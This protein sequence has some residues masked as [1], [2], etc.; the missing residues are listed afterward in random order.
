M[1]SHAEKLIKLECKQP[2]DSQV[3]KIRIDKI[4]IRK[5]KATER[6]FNKKM[7]L[8]IAESIKVD[9]QLQPILLRNHP[10]EPG[11]YEQIA[12]LHRIYAVGTI[13]KRDEIDAYV[14]DCTEESGRM[15]TIAE[16]VFR[17]QPNKEQFFAG[18]SAW[19]KHYEENGAYK[20][21]QAGGQAKAAAGQSQDTTTPDRSPLDD[22]PPDGPT[23]TAPFDVPEK[24]KRSE[25]SDDAEI[26]QESEDQAGPVAPDEP[27]SFRA[28]V[29]AVLGKSKTSAGELI[30]IA[31]AL[32]KMGDDERKIIFPDDLAKHPQKKQLVA[33]A[34]L[35][36]DAR[37]N[38]VK[39]RASGMDWAQ[40][41]E[42][43]ASD[44]RKAGGKAG[45]VSS[46]AKNE[47]DLTDEEW[48]TT[49][50]STVMV[51][52]KKK[53]VFKSDAIA[54]RRWTKKRR[55]LQKEANVFLAECKS[56]KNLKPGPYQ[57][58]IAR[59]FRAKHPN[60]WTCCGICQGTGTR[61]DSNEH[62]GTCNGSG[63][64]LTI[65][66]V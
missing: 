62:C 7:A 51:K 55:R 49:Y 61:K 22:F 26:S 38:A 58:T 42:E 50:C 15:K 41:I 17:T 35:S 20:Q 66:P 34:G 60:D 11:C 45:I 48:I 19:K 14:L 21:G 2:M 39:L 36:D 33:L 13:L 65:E 16:N 44:Y 54:Y 64:K 47:D 18:I 3:Q 30:R 56:D 4:K 31:D 10:T 53:D 6:T 24:S 23:L 29:Q 1:A 40:A 57:T 43:Q 52:L 12:G 25:L 46:T 63:Y 59:A 27:M 28:L 9:G 8:A 32:E 5:P 37:L